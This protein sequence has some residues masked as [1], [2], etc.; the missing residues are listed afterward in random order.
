MSAPAW[1]AVDD[2]TAD[3]LSLVA[4]DQMTP[5]PEEEWAEFVRCLHYAADADGRISPNRLR[6][7]VRG[8]IAPRRI[9]AFTNRAKA[10]GRIVDS[11]EWE[12]SDDREGRNGGKPCRVYRLVAA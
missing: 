11:G 3:L 4:N 8:T 5:R 7:L 12:I 2:E 9:G 1:S 6:P 10:E